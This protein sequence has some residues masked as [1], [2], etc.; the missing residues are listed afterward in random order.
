MKTFANEPPKA[1]PMETPWVWS[2]A[3]EQK[4]NELECSRSRSRVMTDKSGLLR[5]GELM[6]AVE[7]AAIPSLMGMFVYSD[8]TSKV[9]ST[10][11]AEIVVLR[12]IAIRWDVSFR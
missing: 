7:T 1:C 9:K 4:V 8:S 11:S 2:H 3:L 5:S 12:S 10:A 6:K